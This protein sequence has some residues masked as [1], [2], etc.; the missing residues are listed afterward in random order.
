MK[1]YKVEIRVLDT[2]EWTSHAENVDA[3]EDM[4]S[5]G[6]DWD[7]LVQITLQELKAEI[8]KK[9]VDEAGEAGAE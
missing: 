7:H 3:P 6:I 1:S 4:I 8:A 2:D 5:R 9:Q